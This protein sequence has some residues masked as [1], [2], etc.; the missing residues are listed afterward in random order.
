[1]SDTCKVVF[2]GEL[3]QGFD[4]EKIIEAFCEKFSV[5]RVKA[6]K[7]INSGKDVVL[8]GG[9][10]QE[11]AEKYKNVLEKLGMV[12]RIEGKLPDAS[13]SALALEPVEDEEDEKTL[14]IEETSQGEAVEN[15]PKCGSTRMVD[16][17]CLD[18]GVVAEKYLAMQVRRQDE[19]DEKAW[20]AEPDNPYNAPQADLYESLEGEMTG[21]KGVP[22]GHGWAWL[23]KGWWHFKQNPIAWMVGMVVWFLIAIV[24]GLIPVI[25]SIVLNLFT[26][27]IVAGFIIG[28][29]AQDEGEDFT[30][31]HIFAGFSNN[32]GQLVLVGLIYFGAVF[33][34][35]IVLMVGFSGM[36]SMQAMGS[37][38]PDAMM[39]ML[40]SPGFL[41]ALLLGFLM[42]IPL[43][44]AYMFAPALVALDDMKALA[45][46]KLSF[47]GCLKNLLPLTVYG[48]VAMLLI[49]IGSLTF[50]LG[51][52]I[53]L[54][55]IT[56][57]IYSAYRDIYFE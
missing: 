55:V 10:N 48:L 20:Q 27:V 44:M 17:S 42:M 47:I 1:M 11:R 24:V 38:N 14:V 4:P 30:I 23:V 31:N 5:S 3:Q 19:A 56:A 54:P 46:M 53:V 33:L 6:E 41:I 51:L 40:L 12:V 34:L 32:M 7:L 35:T 52:L 36:I 2:S 39:A 57:S 9:L 50:G 25:G 45:A 49:M 29:R 13:A 26:P 37:E 22:T 15:C 21:P 28:C 18:C 16:G 8:K 43:M